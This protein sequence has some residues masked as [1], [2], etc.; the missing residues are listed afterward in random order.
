MKWG[1]ENN[2]QFPTGF[3]PTTT[4]TW[5]RHMGRLVAGASIPGKR[6]GTLSK[7]SPP[8]LSMLIIR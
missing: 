3:E 7:F 8:P 2:L 5:A 1:E 4:K 6:V